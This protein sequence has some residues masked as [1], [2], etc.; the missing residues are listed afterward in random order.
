V[1]HGTPIQGHS[2]AEESVPP[3]GAAAEI[4]G[5][6]SGKTILL[7]GHSRSTGGRVKAAHPAAG[8][9]IESFFH[10]HLA[11]RSVRTAR[12]AGCFPGAWP[13]PSLSEA[14]S[15]TAPSPRERPRRLA[16]LVLSRQERRLQPPEWH[17]L[18]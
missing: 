13:G 6:P 12:P 10:G 3:V 8:G 5:K 18:R 1:T 14:P 9:K 4:P 7:G 2:P 15:P 16:L 11:R 17:S